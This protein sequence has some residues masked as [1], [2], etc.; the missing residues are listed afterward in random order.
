MHRGG[1]G[2]DRTDRF[3]ATVYRIWQQHFFAGV[4]ES[5]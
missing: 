2:I 4:E 1:V 5:I 3:M